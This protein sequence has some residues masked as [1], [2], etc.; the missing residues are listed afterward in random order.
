M[1]PS[2]LLG[3]AAMPGEVLSVRTG[4]PGQYRVRVGGRWAQEANGKGL[5]SRARGAGGRMGE[6]VTEKLTEAR[7]GSCL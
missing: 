3:A 5:C 1:S 7:T 6:R 4:E 2:F